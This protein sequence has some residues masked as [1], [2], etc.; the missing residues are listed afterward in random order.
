VEAPHRILQGVLPAFEHELNAY[1]RHMDR[2]AVLVSN[3]GLLILD[4]A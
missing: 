3:K 2:I 1:A 4:H